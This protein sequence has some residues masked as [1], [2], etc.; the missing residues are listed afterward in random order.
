MGDEDP[1]LSELPNDL[2]GFRCR[3]TPTDPDAAEVRANSKES[4]VKA[5]S[6]SVHESSERE[7]VDPNV[8]AVDDAMLDGGEED[9]GDKHDE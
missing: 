5:P 2:G 1:S 3:P 6:P 7:N 8:D 4:S 9:S